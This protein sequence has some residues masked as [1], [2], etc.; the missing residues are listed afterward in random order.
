M[1]RLL[2]RCI[3]RLP[4]PIAK[5]SEDQAERAHALGQDIQ[6]RYS[7]AVS[8]RELVYRELIK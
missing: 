4:R 6:R 7:I 2:P 3:V 5:G 1:V 8:I